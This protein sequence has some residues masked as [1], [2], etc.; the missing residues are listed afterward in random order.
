MVSQSIR[1]KVQ[2]AMVVDGRFCDGLKPG[3]LLEITVNGTQFVPSD[4]GT[5]K[6]LV[7]MN[8]NT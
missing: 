3:K 4:E 6:K 5:T 8:Y 1:V 2:M 7:K